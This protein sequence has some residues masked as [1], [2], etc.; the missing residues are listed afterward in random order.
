MFELPTVTEPFEVIR[1]RS[2][3]SEQPTIRLLTHC[4]ATSEVGLLQLG[5]LRQLRIKDVS[6]RRLQI[7]NSLP[8]VSRVFPGLVFY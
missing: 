6:F 5:N 1:N 2:S 4:A 3:T 8:S 7:G